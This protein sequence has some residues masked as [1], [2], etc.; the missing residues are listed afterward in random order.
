MISRRSTYISFGFVITSGVYKRRFCEST[1][2]TLLKI[3]VFL[4]SEVG[5]DL[6]ADG[7]KGMRFFFF[8]VKDKLACAKRCE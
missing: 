6:G 2:S 8:F 4:V 1:E 3:A 7:L 5:L